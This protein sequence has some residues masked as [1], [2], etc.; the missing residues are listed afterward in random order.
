[1]STSILWGNTAA[2]SGPQIH[3]AGTGSIDVIYSNVQGDEVHAGAGNINL[4]PLFVGGTKHVLRLQT[5]S[6]C[7]DEGDPELPP[8]LADLDGDG[9][10]AEPLPLDLAGNTRAVGTAVDMGAYEFFEGCGNAIIEAPEECDDGHRVDGD[11]CSA[12]C[13]W[14]PGYGYE[15]C[16]E[17]VAADSESADGRYTLQLDGDPSK[18]WLAY[19]H[20]MAGTPAEYLQLVNIDGDFNFSQYTAGGASPGSN[21]RSHYYRIRLDP[22]TLLVNTAYVDDPDYSVSSG[23]LDDGTNSMSYAQAQACITPEND[24]GLANVDLTGTPF[25]VAE[26]A[27]VTEG[28]RPAGGATYSADR[29]VVDLT[30]GGHCGATRAVDGSLQLEYA[31]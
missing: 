6:P 14:E 1:M 30:G 13:E 26:N 4:D 28:F 3:D 21:V 27:F 12:T 29:K 25:V 2:G 23:A 11:G 16:A 9:D 15:T 10:T 19:C 17:I 8:D 5:E 20:D 7:I 24:A 18:P 31:D 22:A